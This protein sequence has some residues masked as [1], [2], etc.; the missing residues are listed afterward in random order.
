H[1]ERESLLRFLEMLAIRTGVTFRDGAITQVV[2]GEEGVASIKLNSGESLMADL[3]IDATGA[4]SLLLG[5]TLNEQF[6]S[7]A[8]LLCDKAIVATCPR[9][10]NVIQPHSTV[11]TME[12]GWSWRT[13]HERFL[14]CGYAFS[15]RHIS[16][17]QAE[18]QLR[19]IYPG[20]GPLRIVNLV[21]G[22]REN[23]WCG[24]VVAIGNSAAFVEPLAAAGPGMVA[25][26]CQWLARSLVD[27]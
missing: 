20:C 17:E 26:Q 8:G 4:Q 1:V 7:F 27:C 2:R 11:H 24:N 16:I 18:A 22:R 25:F 21:Q 9:P 14:A 13:E 3:F 23:A 15:S 19:Q 6:Q 12:A 10:D 5:Q